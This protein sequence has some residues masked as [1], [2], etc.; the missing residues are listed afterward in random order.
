MKNKKFKWFLLISAFLM[1]SLWSV[2]V[3][4]NYNDH[5]SKG[6]DWEHY[7]VQQ[8]DTL[9]EIAQRYGVKVES[10]CKW[11]GIKDKNLILP[12]QS[13]AIKKEPGSS[14]QISRAVKSREKVSY[15]VQPGDTLAE[16]AQRFQVSIDR[17][18]SWNSDTIENKHLIHPGQRI[19]IYQEKEKESDPNPIAIKPEESSR[20]TAR[21]SYRVQPG[22]TLA[23]IAQRFHLSLDRILAL[24][25]QIEDKNIIHKGQRIFLGRDRNV[26]SSRDFG[27]RE[28]RILQRVGKRTGVDWKILYGL[29]K[30]ESD[31]GRVM[32]GDNGKAL[33]WFQ[34]HT[35][36]HPE[37]TVS[38]AMDLEHAAEWAAEYLIE[39]GYDQNKFR[40]LQEYNGSPDNP[41][42]ARRARQIMEY[43][44]RVKV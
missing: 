13:L 37:V 39:M 29:C 12:G 42:T 7:Q 22:D 15:Q 36:Y 16:I 14:S 27:P 2:N 34:I 38:Q 30:K 9:T 26:F 21:K 3:F 1:F 17:I 35:G 31:L 4:A 11:N 24:N 20:H 43:A 19:T 32:V 10:I 44:K 6:G 25:P 8:G 5:Q 40:A 18:M 23:E 28:K 41:V 33:G